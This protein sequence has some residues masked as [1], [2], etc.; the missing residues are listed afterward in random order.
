MTLTVMRGLR[1]AAFLHPHLAVTAHTWQ[2]HLPWHLSL[3]EF[4]THS[5]QDLTVSVLLAKMKGNSRSDR[6]SGRTA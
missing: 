5:L 6:S 3:A 4:L 2:G 1:R